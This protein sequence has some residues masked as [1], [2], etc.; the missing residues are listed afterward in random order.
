[1]GDRTYLKLVIHGH[2]PSLTA[3]QGITAAMAMENLEPV[4]GGDFEHEFTRAFLAQ[5]SPEFEHH[6]CNYADI[7]SVEATLQMHKVAYHIEHGEGSDYPGGCKAWAP[8]WDMWEEP[9]A[10]DGEPYIT[11]SDLERAVTNAPREGYTIEAWINSRLDAMKKA[12]GEGLPTFS[13]ADEVRDQFAEAIA[14]AAL[15]LKAA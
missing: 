2:I 3:Y 10:R 8:E 1:M 12:T 11:L 14:K 6:E 7:S 5:E 15:G 13:M 4:M 9:S